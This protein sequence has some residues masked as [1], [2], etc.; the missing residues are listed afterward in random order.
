V[1]TVPTVG[2]SSF[3]SQ[4]RTA[5]RHALLEQPDPNLT[6]ARHHALRQRTVS[7]RRIGVSEP[8]DRGDWATSVGLCGSPAGGAPTQ[9]CVSTATSVALRLVGPTADTDAMGFHHEEVIGAAR[10]GDPD[11][12][13]VLWRH[14]QP[15]V[16]RYLSARRIV[17]PADVASQIWID[18]AGSIARFDGDGE[19][20]RRWLFTIAHR[21]VVDEVRRSVRRSRLAERVG[22]E[23]GAAVGA[24]VGTDQMYERDTALARALDMLSGLPPEMA[25]AVAL[26]VIAEL[27]F[28]DVATVMSC[29][30]GNARVLVH[31]GLKRLAAQVAV[32]ISDA[33]A[34]KSLP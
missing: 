6:D 22:T 11:A 33:E 24:A 7:I 17:D 26:R 16:L 13:A 5:G 31:R 1:Q 32:T 9:P 30:E 23:A 14:H 19:D 8:S 18:V 10:R 12:F 29:T 15:Q 21:R 20:F 27:P 3:S 28:A 34:M 25:E 2:R 4:T